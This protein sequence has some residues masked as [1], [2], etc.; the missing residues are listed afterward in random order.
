MTETKS[1]STD[2]STNKS[3]NFI[4]DIINT[5]GLHYREALS[6]INESR[7][8][9][10]LIPPSIDLD[11][12]KQ[13]PKGAFISHYNINDEEATA[14]KNGLEKKCNNSKRNAKN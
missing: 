4:V 9:P 6:K 1:K 10:F 12:E 14:R 3:S 11:K 8:R 5:T 13:Y 7:G 2:K